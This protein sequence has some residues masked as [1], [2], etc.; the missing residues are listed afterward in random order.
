MELVS[1]KTRITKMQMVYANLAL[2][3][4]VSLAILPQLALFALETQ[5]C[6]LEHRQQVAYVIPDSTR[7]EP[8]AYHVQS[9]AS[10]AVHQPTAML[11][12][13]VFTPLPI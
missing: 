1:V 10:I 6:S 4:F 8:H 13:T 2:I 7:M 3:L 9:A 5:H 11:A 12:K